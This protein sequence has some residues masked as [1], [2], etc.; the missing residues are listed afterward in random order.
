M[1]TW[2]IILVFVV[3]SVAYF[4]YVT[5]EDRSHGYY[6]EGL[7][8][9]AEPGYLYVPFSRFRVKYTKAVEDLF[10]PGAILEC[11]AVYTGLIQ[12]TQAFGVEYYKKRSELCYKFSY[13][14]YDPDEVKNGITINVAEV[15]VREIEKLEF[16]LSSKGISRQDIE[17]FESF[18]RDAAKKIDDERRFDKVTEALLDCIPY[19]GP[20]MKLFKVLIEEIANR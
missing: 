10:K 4:A 1:E 2:T 11:E 20:W 12:I 5:Y 3:L 13:R 17:Y 19:A 16:T 9:H 15:Y 6:R 8:Y 7:P 18:L 14:I